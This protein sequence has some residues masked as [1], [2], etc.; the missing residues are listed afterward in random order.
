MLLGDKVETFCLLTPA[1]WWHANHPES[2]S[3]LD[4]KVIS[5]VNTLHHWWGWFP[6]WHNCAFL[7]MR[8]RRRKQMPC[9]RWCHSRNPGHLVW[10]Q[11]FSS[12]EPPHFHHVSFFTLP[13]ARL[14]FVV[15]E[16]QCFRKGKGG[17]QCGKTW[18]G[19]RLVVLSQKLAFLSI[20]ILTVDGITLLAFWKHEL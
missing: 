17:L 1:I 14:C 3:A 18:L 15:P 20:F 8:S 11:T 4:T 16:S 7:Q 5:G 19:W 13:N 12:T 10:W 2:R 9:S 6:T